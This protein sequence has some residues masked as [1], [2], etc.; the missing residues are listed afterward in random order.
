M[1]L[2]VDASVAL[3][4]VLQEP[5]SAQ[6]DALL[7]EDL[8]APTYLLAESASVLSRKVRLGELG[9]EQAW[10]NMSLLRSVGVRLVGTLD[11]L[12]AALVLSVD[13]AHPIYDCLYLA[14]AVEERSM[15][16][17]SDLQ[18]AER[19]GQRRRDLA[20]RVW[21]L[22]ARRPPGAQPQ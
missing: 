2:I 18:F 15:L 14:L 9:L 10:H 4:W 17:T 6:A 3:K 12:E 5:D 21:V 7:S 20:A 22:G 19:V 8:S 11:L 16:V 1:G 13:L